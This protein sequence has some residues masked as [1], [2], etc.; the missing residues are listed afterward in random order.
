VQSCWH[1]QHYVLLRAWRCLLITVVFIF[2]FSVRDLPTEIE[3]FVLRTTKIWE[4]WVAVNNMLGAP[5]DV[6]V[7][8]RGSDAD[9]LNARGKLPVRNNLSPRGQ[10][11]L[12][13]F[14]KN[15]IRIYIDLLN[16][17][18][19]LSD[20]DVRDALVVIQRNC[21]SVVTSLVEVDAITS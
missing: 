21:P 13:H 1:A 15:D 17:A 14:L 6:I 8:E 16:R 18:V 4:D 2:F 5:R 11:I 3:V 19:N 12:C 10:E 20:D 7:P 9:V